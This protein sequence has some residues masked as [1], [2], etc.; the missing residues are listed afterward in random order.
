MMDMGGNGVTKEQV[1]AFGVLN[2]NRDVPAI[3]FRHIP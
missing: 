2:D 1:K 3:V